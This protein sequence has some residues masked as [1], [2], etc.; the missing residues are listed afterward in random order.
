MA[1]EIDLTCAITTNLALGTG[2][3]SLHSVDY[4]AR[5]EPRCI[6]IKGVLMK[7]IIVGV[8][9]TLFA[10][11]LIAPSQAATPKAL[12]IIDSYF[13]SK[14][15][16]ADVSCITLANTLCTDVVSI[17]SASLSSDVNHGNAMAEVAKKQNKSLSIILLRATTPSA[18]TVNPINAGNFIDALIW[19]N[20]NS[21]KVGAVSLSRYFNGNKVC[22]PASTNTAPYGGVSGADKTIRNLIS[23]LNSKGIPVFVSTGNKMGAK[24]DYPACITDTVSVSTGG[25]NSQGTI[26]SVNAFDSNTDYFASSEFSNYNSTVFGLIPQTTSSATAAVAAQWLSTG[27]PTSKIVQVNP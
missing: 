4:E 11:A 21:S 23:T 9:I 1:D 13:D 16:N 24:V 27:R 8:T 10:G 6:E 17:K 25:I 19:V 20:A 15:Y 5:S 18:K 12:V 22:S 26:V 7:R 3:F 14:V 2:R